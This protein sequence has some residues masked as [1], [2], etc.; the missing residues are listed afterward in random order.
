[1]RSTIYYVDC[2]GQDE[3]H[4]C[5][6]HLQ[7]EDSMLLPRL[8]FLHRWVQSNGKDF[9]AGHAPEGADPM[10]WAVRGDG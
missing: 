3:D 4:D 6:E 8:M 2:D 9:C 5:D 1:M 7:S 10:D